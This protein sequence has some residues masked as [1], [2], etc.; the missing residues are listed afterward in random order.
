[1][2]TVD[3]GLWTS[4]LGWGQQQH[5]VVRGAGCAELQSYWVAANWKYVA[6]AVIMQH[7]GNTNN[8]AKDTFSWPRIAFCS[9]NDMGCLTQWGICTLNHVWRLKETLCFPHKTLGLQ[10]K[11]EELTAN[12]MFNIYSCWM[13]LMDCYSDCLHE[14]HSTLFIQIHLSAVTASH[15]SDSLD[16]AGKLNSNWYS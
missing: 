4:W 2:W 9:V 11:C 12:S 13:V 5:W 14:S 7:S 16:V 3:C 15:F 8:I 6:L 10:V 1:M